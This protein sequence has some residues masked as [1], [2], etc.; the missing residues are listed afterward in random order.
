MMDTH[1]W[2]R[3]SIP[4]AHQTHPSLRGCVFAGEAENQLIAGQLEIPSS[5]CNC[6]VAIK[7]REGGRQNNS[8]FLFPPAYPSPTAW[9]KKG[10][11]SLGVK[12]SLDEPNCLGAAFCE[13]EDHRS[14]FLT[15]RFFLSNAGIR[16][17]EKIR[18]SQSRERARAERVACVLSSLRVLA[19][20]TKQ[21]WK[22][23]DEMP[24]LV[25]AGVSL[26]TQAGP[27]HNYTSAPSHFL[28]ESS[29]AEKLLD[30]WFHTQG[31]N[32]NLKKKKRDTPNFKLV[33]HGE[34]CGQYG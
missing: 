33:I 21:V 8:L 17:S 7:M 22:T 20:P 16:Y 3:P 34:N 14:N 25:L 2:S 24:V 12:T 31:M 1:S 13:R 10:S 5:G 18:K 6:S 26:K 9:L 29:C 4:P 19:K 11:R 15:V 27:S 32:S 28:L 30:L 23:L